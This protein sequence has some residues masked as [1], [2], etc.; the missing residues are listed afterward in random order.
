MPAPDAERY[1]RLARII[2]EEAKVVSDANSKRVLEEMA[3]RYERLAERMD[4]K[5]KGGDH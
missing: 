2:R 4:G 1:R 3:A 5:G